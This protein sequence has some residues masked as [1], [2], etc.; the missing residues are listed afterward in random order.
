VSRA[1]AQAETPTPPGSKPFPAIF[2]GSVASTARQ[3]VDFTASVIEGHDDNVLPAAVEPS[4]PGPYQSTGFYTDFSPQVTFESRSR[5]SIRVAGGSDLRYFRDLGKAV[6]LEHNVEAELS[7][8]LGKRT[9]ALVGQSISYAPASLTG[10]FINPADPATAFT[11]P[12]APGDVA[13][14]SYVLHPDRSVRYL[15]R[16]SLN[17]R[18]SRRGALSLDSDFDSMTYVDQQTAQRAGF[19]DLRSYHI[20]GSFDYQFAR[21]VGLQFR[22]AYGNAKYASTSAPIED[23]DFEIGTKYQKRLSAS[24]KLTIEGGI[25]STLFGFASAPTAQP[26]VTPVDGSATGPSVNPGTATSSS[27]A[28]VP[29]PTMQF[30]M[31]G[32]FVVVWDLARTWNATGGYGRGVSY[33]AGLRDAVFSNSVT[34]GAQGFVNRRTDVSFS[35]EYSKGTFVLPSEDF[36]TLAPSPPFR[37]YSGT[38]SV[39]VALMRSWAAYVDYVYYFYHFDNGAGLPSA[40]PRSLTRNSVQTGLTLWVPIMRRH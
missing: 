14:S 21:N 23:H 8:P 5:S 37:T 22:Y 28:V 9:S 10:L 34:L 17:E 26:A 4:V 32:R 25:G 16:G 6:A 36:A 39:R 38:V 29:S 13:A 27:P 12:P 2:G 18:I 3:T 24:R 7:T 40:F 11:L 15:T 19:S 1:L 33:V 35:G 20:G 30:G 31:T